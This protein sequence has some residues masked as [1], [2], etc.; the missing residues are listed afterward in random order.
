MSGLVCTTAQAISER[1]VGELEAIDA[2]YPNPSATVKPFIQSL[3]ALAIHA[4]L[5]EYATNRLDALMG[6]VLPET[7]VRTAVVIPFQKPEIA[8]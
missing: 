7:G 2:K 4:A 8:S 5:S 6:R 3:K 1:L